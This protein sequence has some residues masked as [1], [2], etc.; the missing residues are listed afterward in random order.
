MLFPLEN[1][2]NQFIITDSNLLVKLLLFLSN[3]LSL[4]KFSFLIT[5]SN[6]PLFFNSFN[7]L[8]ESSSSNDRAFTSFLSFLNLSIK[9]S[10]P[11]FKESL[12]LLFI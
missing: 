11:S 4:E 6:F 10:S 12:N 8:F 5:I 3:N 7:V 2:L 9:Y 1:V